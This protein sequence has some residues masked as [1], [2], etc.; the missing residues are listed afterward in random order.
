MRTVNLGRT[1]FKN[2]QTKSARTRHLLQQRR[3]RVR[4]RLVKGCEV[5]QACGTPPTVD[6]LVVVADHRQ[7]SRA[8]GRG[9]AQQAEQLELTRVCVLELVDCSGERECQNVNWK[10][11]FWK[12]VDLC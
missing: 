9:R 10:L 11:L 2:I 3:D 7:P 4:E 5:A 6:L 8:T 12:G 1:C